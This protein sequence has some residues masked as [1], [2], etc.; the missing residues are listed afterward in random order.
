MIEKIL[1]SSK[2]LVD[3][4]SLDFK[5]KYFGDVK[6]LLENWE[7]LIWFFGKRWTGKTYMALQ[8]LK[9]FWWVYILAHDFYVVKEWIFKIIENLYEN[10]WYK[11]FVIDEVHRYPNWCIEIKNIYDLFSDIKLIVTWSQK[12]AVDECQV[13][14]S[15]RFYIKYFDVLDFCEF[16]IYLWKLKNWCYI[17]ANV[18]EDNKKIN[19]FIMSLDFDILHFWNIYKRWWAYPFTAKL[20]EDTAVY[21]LQSVI[22]ISIYEDL[23]VVFDLSKEEIKI[24]KN[25][26]L[27]LANSP[28]FEFSSK[29]IMKKLNINKYSYYD[30]LQW[31]EKVDLISI[32]TNF[33]KKGW[34]IWRE[35][36][37]VLF[38]DWNLRY[39]FLSVFE[40]RLLWGLRE[41]W[42]VNF[43]KNLDF[44]IWWSS[45]QDFIVRWADGNIW[46]FEIWWKNKKIKSKYQIWEKFRLVLDDIVFAED[47]KIPLWLFGMMKK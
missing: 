40:D 24:V 13:D 14:L 30:I 4:I 45:K 28:V 47:F 8:F 25:F 34:K 41:D 7:R 31:L 20:K 35:F 44:A 21:K 33:S 22:D 2:R 10:F 27:E 37:K 39:S 32:V 43:I 12:V 46:S 9:Q 3:M 19:E 29:N 38:S 36:K 16:L 42:F 26:L 15:R 18:L 1:K 11:F 23:P 17:S 6:D 5:R